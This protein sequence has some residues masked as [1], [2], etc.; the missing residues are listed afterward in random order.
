MKTKN[1]LNMAVPRNIWLNPIRYF[2]VQIPNKHVRTA[3]YHSSNYDDFENIYRKSTMVLYF[4]V[5]DTTFPKLRFWILIFYWLGNII[6]STKKTNITNKFYL[7]FFW[8]NVWK[9]IKSDWGTRKRR[10]ER[11]IKDC[12]KRFVHEKYLKQDE[13][14][15]KL[16]KGSY[17]KK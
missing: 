10:K 8:E 12:R 9:K 5:N 2:I 3:F 14:F 15:Q 16:Y 13:I 17:T 1:V 4:W 7:F 11:A 6:T